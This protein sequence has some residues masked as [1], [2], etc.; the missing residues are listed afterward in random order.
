[1]EIQKYIEKLAKHSFLGKNFHVLANAENGIFLSENQD[2]K[3]R[4]S[5]SLFISKLKAVRVNKD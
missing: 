1:M 3:T 5:N 2:C 4:L